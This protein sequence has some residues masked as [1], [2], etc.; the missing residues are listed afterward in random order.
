MLRIEGVYKRLGGRTVVDG[1]DL[2]CEPGTICVVTGDNGTGKST[3]LRM[4]AGVLEPDRGLVE[5][6]GASLARAPEAARQKLGYVPEAA[7]PPGHMTGEELFALVQALKQ[8]PPLDPARRTA[9]GLE[10][11]AAERIARLSLGQRRRVCLAAALIGNPA[12]L[13]L[14]EPTNGLDRAGVT[15]LVALLE[16]ER[17][18]GA[19]IVV[20]THDR[21]FAAALAGQHFHMQAGRLM[22]GTAL[23]REDPPGPGQAGEDQAVAVSVL[24]SVEG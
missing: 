7:N 4:I 5:I 1:I 15:T 9:L 17:A 6:A 23:Q 20:A 14:D 13:V 3:L 18:A 2:A 19:I 8:A 10:T 22:A 11:I 21:D 16:A 24:G 12:V